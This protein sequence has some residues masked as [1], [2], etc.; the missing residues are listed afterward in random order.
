MTM[1]N[2]PKKEIIFCFELVE[3]NN[4]LQMIYQKNYSKLYHKTIIKFN[5]NVLWVI[6]LLFDNLKCFI[7]CKLRQFKNISIFFLYFSISL[8][9]TNSNFFK[10]ITLFVIFWLSQLR[11]ANFQF[12]VQFFKL[13]KL[14]IVQFSV[15]S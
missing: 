3:L 1:F 14:F 7:I 9:S 12:S 6:S 11:V 8:C 2:S 13:L 4:L 5:K 15:F 10:P